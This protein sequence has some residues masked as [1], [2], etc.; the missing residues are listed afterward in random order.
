MTATTLSEHFGTCPDCGRHDGYINIG[1]SHWF[2][3]REHETRWI[4]GHNLFD[5]WKDETREEQQTRYDELDFGTFA[6]IAW[7]ETEARGYDE[8]LSE[9]PANPTRVRANA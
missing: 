8:H 3:C 4:A 2:Y 7:D 9:P 1:R 6:Y 5:S